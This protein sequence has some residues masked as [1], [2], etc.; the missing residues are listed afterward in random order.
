MRSP[1][2]GL[3]SLPHQKHPEAFVLGVSR[4]RFSC[5]G[6]G[7][8][9]NRPLSQMIQLCRVR[10]DKRCVP[11]SLP[12]PCL[13]MVSLRTVPIDIID[14]I[15][16][17]LVDREF[18]IIVITISFYQP[19]FKRLI[20]WTVYD[21]DFRVRYELIIRSLCMDKMSNVKSVLGNCF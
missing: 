15:S 20:P 6:S 21:V 14:I 5:V 17:S 7:G 19:S 8:T 10:W 1:R 18:S 2:S 4:Y 13:C 16:G 12:Y 9:R 3:R 11:L